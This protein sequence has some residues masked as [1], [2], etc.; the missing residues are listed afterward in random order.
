M[1]PASSGG[2]RRLSNS[3][4]AS[5]IAA[6]S[7]GFTGLPASSSRTRRSK[8]SRCWASWPASAVYGRS[9]SA[10]GHLPGGRGQRAP[11][12]RT[13]RPPAQGARGHAV[14]A[15]TGSRPVTSASLSE[16]PGRRGDRCTSRPATPDY[17]RPMTRS[18]SSRCS[19][20]WAARTTFSG[21]PAAAF[22]ASISS[23]SVSTTWSVARAI[24]THSSAA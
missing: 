21:F 20:R 5:P 16:P 7:A 10:T 3:W 1:R 18:R 17:R 9:A 14:G 22:R 12:G 24:R 13:R 15:T 6:F 23:D 4:S 11:G 8:A 19:R 2:R